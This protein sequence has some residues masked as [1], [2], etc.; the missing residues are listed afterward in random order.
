MISIRKQIDEADHFSSRFEALRHAHLALTGALPEAGK[1]ADPDLAARAKALLDQAALAVLYEASTKQLEEAGSVA[2]NQLRT[3]CRANTT[4]I[5]ERDASLKEVAGAFADCIKGF[6]GYGERHNSHLEGIAVE[7]ESL[8]RL[9]DVNEL[10]HRLHDHVAKLRA[11]VDAMRRESE[12]AIRHFESQ[13]VSFQ[14][15]L[16][17]ARRE[18]KFDRLTGLGNR[19]EAEQ[20]LRQLDT[21][22]PPVS[23]LLFDILGFREINRKNGAPFGDKVLQALAHTLVECFPEKD[24]LFRWGADE[25]LVI[26]EG[27]LPARLEACKLICRRFA[28]DSNYS[29]NGIKRVTAS[30]ACGGTEYRPGDPVDDLYRRARQNLDQGG[31]G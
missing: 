27:R 22:K 29:V 16:E 19:R 6:K 13:I 23:V 21:R 17:T 7:F 5:E 28:T 18:S 3:I 1:A 15:R 14:Q 24:S 12:E 8:S 30:V 2:L 31:G 20:Q 4:A 10:R 9:N 26:A 25:F 11:S